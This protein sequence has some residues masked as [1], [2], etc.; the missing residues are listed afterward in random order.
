MVVLR[1][2]R[3]VDRIV[4]ALPQPVLWVTPRAAPQAAEGDGTRPGDAGS[5][6][7][8][9]RDPE[10]H[11]PD[12][13]RDQHHRHEDR[14]RPGRVIRRRADVDRERAT[15]RVGHGEQPED[16]PEVRAA[17]H[18]AE[19]RR[20]DRD[21]GAGPEAM[22][23]DAED[24]Q[25]GLRGDE[26]DRRH[27]AATDEHGRREPDHP[28]PEAVRQ[29]AADDLPCHVGECLQA[30]RGGGRLGPDPGVDR[31]R[32]E[33]LEDALVEDPDRRGTREQDP[34]PPRPDRP[35]DA[36]AAFRAAR[37]RDLVRGRD[38]TRGRGLM[39]A[40]RPGGN[41]R[42]RRAQGRLARA[43][44]LADPPAGAGRWRLAGRDRARTGRDRAGGRRPDGPDRSPRARPRDDDGRPARHHP[45][46]GDADQA[47]RHEHQGGRPPAGGLDQPGGDRQRDGHADPGTRVGDPERE[48]GH[49]LVAARDRGRGPD[50]GELEA[51]R[52]QH[53]VGQ[54]HQRDV[55]GQVDGQPAGRQ[56]DHRGRQQV[57]VGELVVGSPEE[58][59]GERGDQQEHRPGRDRERA[60]D[61]ELVGEGDR[62]RRERVQPAVGD[63]PDHE[64]A[65][66]RERDTRRPASDRDGHRS[67]P[68]VRRS[69]L[70][71]PPAGPARSRMTCRSVAAPGPG[72]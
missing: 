41:A 47:R 17:E 65:D 14:I 57:A 39:Q 58:R 23:G 11:G 15:D 16:R 67:G 3:T 63:R 44:R 30:E 22:D 61:P 62:D 5:R 12:R 7:S 48:P 19:G 46:E 32:D 69:A 52:H 34:E 18:I 53:G 49:P 45:D 66:E 70:S 1:D 9:A 64:R 13:Q 71:G 38:R 33:G 35:P 37:R 26:P 10:R 29:P 20:A 59:A 55:A 4:G 25:P 72:A 50:E 27:D 60:A 31:A 21:R 36:P 51:D 42:L 54:D 56:Q 40:A 43:H 2:G 8:R 24:G 28:P 68:A 6:P